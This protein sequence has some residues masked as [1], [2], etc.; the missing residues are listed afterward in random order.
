MSILSD[1]IYLWPIPSDN[2]FGNKIKITMI[3]SQCVVVFLLFFF[4]LFFC[5]CFK[6]KINNSLDL[7]NCTAFIVAIKCGVWNIW[8]S[9]WIESLNDVFSVKFPV[10]SELAF[11]FPVICI[12]KIRLIRFC[13]FTFISFQQILNHISDKWNTDQAT[14]DC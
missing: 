13:I 3:Q 5:Y 1:R 14:H 7:V 8:T 12:M 6:M 11:F 2:Q 10:L 9:I 4:S